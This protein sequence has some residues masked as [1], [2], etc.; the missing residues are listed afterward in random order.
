MSAPHALVKILG[1]ALSLE[2]ILEQLQKLVP[3]KCKWDPMLQE[4]GSYVVT[5]P[6]KSELQRSMI[7]G[8]MDVKENGVSTGVKLVF[9]EWHDKEEG[10]LL[11]KV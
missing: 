7:Y 6:S 1:G 11:P 9:E 8:G 2:K 5:F 10:F 3:G 4:D